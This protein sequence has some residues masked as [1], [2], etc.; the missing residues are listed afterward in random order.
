MYCQI[1][2]LRPKCLLLNEGF[3]CLTL[4]LTSVVYDFI[5]Y[6]PQS[7]GPSTRDDL[8]VHDEVAHD[9]VVHKKIGLAQPIPK[10]PWK[11]GEKVKHTIP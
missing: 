9:I 8:V 11:P 5:H 10:L 3:L 7:K 1:Y 4:S 6:S 2:K